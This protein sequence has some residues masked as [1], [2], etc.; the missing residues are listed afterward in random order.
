MIEK[1]PKVKTVMGLMVGD[2]LIPIDED[3]ESEGFLALVSGTVMRHQPLPDNYL[4]SL[5]SRIE[6]ARDPSI[7]I[8]KGIQKQPVNRY[9][10]YYIPNHTAS[11]EEIHAFAHADG[12]FG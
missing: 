5:R 11:R 2:R 6:N 4:E 10:N 7:P 1:L 12:G 8:V 9:V 3:R